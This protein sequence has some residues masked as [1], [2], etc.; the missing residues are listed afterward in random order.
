[1]TEDRWRPIQG[2]PAYEVSDHGRVRRV[3]A[4]TVRDVGP[5]STRAIGD[6]YLYVTLFRPGE[7]KMHLVHR[8]VAAAF[9]GP[10]P[11]GL[12]VNHIDGVKSNAQVSNLEYVTRAE[13]RRHAYRLR[14]QVAEGERNGYAKLTD[15]AVREIRRLAPRTVAERRSVAARFSVSASTVGDVLRRRTWTHVSALPAAA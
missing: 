14:L 13:N 1:M 10:C 7:R 15:A 12:E 6:G 2:W 4:S 8:L 5:V 3:V 11:A 9:L